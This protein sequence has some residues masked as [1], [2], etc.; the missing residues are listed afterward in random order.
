MTI[1]PSMEKHNSLAFLVSSEW[2]LIV[3]ILFLDFSR[4]EFW[5]KFRV[6]FKERFEKKERLKNKDEVGRGKMKELI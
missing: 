6:G 2:F 1:F 3:L 4:S 5:A